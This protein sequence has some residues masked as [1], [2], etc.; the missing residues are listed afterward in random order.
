MITSGKIDQ[1]KKKIISWDNVR[2]TYLRT[3]PNF[4]V[5]RGTTY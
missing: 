1:K 3:M 2:E 4:L 5:K